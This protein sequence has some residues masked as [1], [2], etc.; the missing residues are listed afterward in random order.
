MVKKKNKIFQL[1]FLIPSTA[2][3]LR[4]KK[5]QAKMTFLELEFWPSET[6]ISKKEATSNT[7]N[8]VKLSKDSLIWPP[9][10]KNL[11]L[12]NPIWEL[13]SFPYSLSKECS[14]CSINKPYL[15]SKTPTSIP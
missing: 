4:K 9:I 1:D 3:L 6:I 5:A 10:T 8:Y 7:P 13:T 2:V 14:L 11:P 15:F 12:T